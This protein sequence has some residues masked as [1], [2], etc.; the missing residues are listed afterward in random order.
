MSKCHRERKRGTGR[1]ITAALVVL[2]A[3]SAGGCEASA[4]PVIHRP[5]RPLYD[6]AATCEK[7]PRRPPNWP[8]AADF[9]LR[10]LLG[11]TMTAA[12]T[13]AKEH[14]LRLR[15]VEH[16]GKGLVVTDDALS[17]RVD[18]AVVKGIVTAIRGIE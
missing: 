6:R 18:V 13:R 14:A 9:D 5:S 17:N 11:L 10:R 8:C 12:S 3:A 7:N 1:R 16:D 2:V 4:G 15:V